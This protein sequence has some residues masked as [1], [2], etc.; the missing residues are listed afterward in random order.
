MQYERINNNG[1]KGVYRSMKE[2]RISTS[3]IIP[4]VADYCGYSQGTVR[5]VIDAYTK[6]IFNI[7]KNNCAVYVMNL[8]IIH[9]RTIKALPER[10]FKLPTTGEIIKLDATLAC[11]TPSF[12]FS[13][14]VREAVREKT[15]GVE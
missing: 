11:K 1:I 12:K 6:V 4:L 14:N 8:G 15:K 13:K 7:L 10:D 3:E 2:K 9:L 5:E